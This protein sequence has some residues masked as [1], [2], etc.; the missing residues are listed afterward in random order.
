MKLKVIVF[1]T[2]VILAGVSSAYL[3][4]VLAANV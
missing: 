3:G 1:V 2:T 4:A